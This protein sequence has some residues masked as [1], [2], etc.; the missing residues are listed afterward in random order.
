MKRTALFLV[1]CLLCAALVSCGGLK[2]NYV[3]ETDEIND[4]SDGSTLV[5]LTMHY[6]LFGGSDASGLINP[7]VKGL[8][9]EYRAYPSEYKAEAADLKAGNEYFTPYTLDLDIEVVETVERYVSLKITDSRYLGGAHGSAKVYG[10]VFDAES[11]ELQTE[12]EILGIDAA[13]LGGLIYAELERM[14]A[15]SPEMYYEDALGMLDDAMMSMSFYAEGNDL[16]FVIQEYKIA[17]Y[18]A[19]TQYVRIPITMTE[20]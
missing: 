13:E 9:D 3:D 14:I 2:Y 18:A 6:P 19:G 16:V 8:V 12:L 10:A 5:S 15:E 1:L 11:G 20:E 17:P 7:I 4:A